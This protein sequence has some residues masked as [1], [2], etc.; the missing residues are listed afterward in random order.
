MRG[1]VAC[2]PWWVRWLWVVC[3]VC[4]PLLITYCCCHFW[5]LLL[6]KIQALCERVG[7]L[8]TLVGEMVVGEAV[9]GE[10]VGPLVGEI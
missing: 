10:D 7:C 1:L 5:S 2:M 8:H 3:I 4:R 9:V 6:S